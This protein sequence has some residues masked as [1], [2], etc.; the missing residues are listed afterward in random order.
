VKTAFIIGSPRSGT[1]ILENILNCHPEVAEWYEPYYLWE[2]YFSAGKGDAWDEK[3]FSNRKSAEIKK[4]FKIFSEKSNKSI[5]LDKS[6]THAFNIRLI[7]KIFPDA[8]WIHILRDGR[9]VT[10]SIK[11]EWDKRRR[12]VEDRDF[13][14]FLRSGYTMLRRQ[15]FWRY[16]YMAL[17]YELASC[18]DARS[19]KYLNK[20]RWSGQIGWGPRFPGWKEYLQKH[21]SLE[22]NAMQWLKSVQAARKNWDIIPESNRLEICY[23]EL[24]QSPEKTIGY[25]FKLL[26]ADL[27][28]NFFQNIPK[29]E[30]D[31]FYKWKAGFTKEEIHTIK[32]IIGPLIQ[33]L[34]YDDISQW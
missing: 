1:T 18:L 9:D 2:R 8:K 21:S 19:I 5:V 15:P 6:P 12:M 17:R 34:G 23:E 13:R 33:E 16:R 25:I 32:P 30:N 29:L 22:F 11:R 4:E 20:A 7:N 28:G 10:L 3:E 27:P 26:G 31:N 14:R 24:L